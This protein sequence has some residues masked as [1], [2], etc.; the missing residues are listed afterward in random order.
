MTTPQVVSSAASLPT[1]S[2]E[3]RRAQ[4]RRFATDAVLIALGAT[5]AIQ[6]MAFTSTML[7][8][9]CLVLAPALL[10]T[11]PT[12]GQWL[13]LAL[14]LVGFVAFFVSSR[15][16]DLGL[17]DQQVVQWASFAVYFVG[18]V[19]LAGRD[20][21]RGFSILCGIA[22]GTLIYY[23]LPG[24]TYASLH[25]LADL[26]KY[27][28]APWVTTIAL[29]VLTV[30]R[31]SVQLQAGFL[32][33]LAGFSLEQNYRS[34]ATVCIGAAAVLFVGW[35]AAGRIPRWMQLGV[36]AAFAAALYTVVPKI[37]LSGIAGEAIQRKTEL[38]TMSGV[39]LLLAGRTESPLSIAAILDRPW[40]GWGIAD[41]ISPEV[42][43]RAKTIAIWI[44]FDPTLPVETTWY[45]SNGRVSL[46]SVLLAAWAEGGVLAALLPLGLLIAALA[47]IWNAPRYGRW[48]ALAVVVSVQAVWDLLFSPTSYNILPTFAMLAVLFA[49]YHLPA[50]VPPEAGPTD[51]RK[52]Q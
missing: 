33:L 34:H 30:L 12:L 37:A 7:S 14:A 24:N 52:Q 21:E 25:V 5:S 20:L 22:I 46:H 48:A 42:F 8:A 2:F 49:A 38:Q 28:W 50:K 9:A 15:I 13:P 39:P 1:R 17:L 31:V 26:W 19:V 40:F 10:L 27:A 45:L 51:A 23:E 11:R 29:Y 3:M 43:D 35:L 16:N 32:L 47:I 6:V 44:G 18:F 41:N 4:A 36:V